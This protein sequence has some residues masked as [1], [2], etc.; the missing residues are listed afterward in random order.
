MMGQVQIGNGL[1]MVGIHCTTD[2]EFLKQEFKHTA[3]IEFI[4]ARDAPNVAHY[5]RFV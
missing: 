5:S 3:I 4:Y 1:E 2:V